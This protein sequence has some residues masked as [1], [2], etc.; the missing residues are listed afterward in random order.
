M[1]ELTGLDAGSSMLLW[2]TKSESCDLGVLCVCMRY[3][4]V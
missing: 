4:A 3:R 2:S 1:S